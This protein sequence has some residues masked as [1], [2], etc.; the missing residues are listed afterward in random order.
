MDYIDIS[1]SIMQS[2]IFIF[3][4]NYCIDEIK[5][6]NKKFIRYII[7][8]SAIIIILPKISNSILV[9]SF[10]THICTLVLTAYSFY[11]QKYKNV[12]IIYSLIYSILIAWIF[13]FGNLSFGILGQILPSSYTALVTATLMYGSQILLFCLCY[14]FRTKIKQ[15]YKM[16]IYENISIQYIILFSFIP[17]FLN[18]FNF[19]TYEL[20]NSYFMYLVFVA[21][22][23]FLGVSIYSF[24]KIIKKANYISKLNRT[25][26]NKNDELKRIKNSYGLQMSCLYELCDVGKYDSVTSL[27]K[28]IINENGTNEVNSSTNSLSLLSLATRHAIGDEITILIEDKADLKLSAMDEIELYRIIVNIVNNAKRAMKNRGTLIARSFQDLKNILITIENDG[29]KIPEEVI[30]KIFE[31][32]FTTKEN[33]DKNHGYGLSIAKEL[34]EKYN[35]KIFVESNEVITKFTISLPIKNMHIC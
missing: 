26:T 7:F 23:I 19:I 31:L 6:N 25:L 20:D 16:I 4:I 9:S 22:F 18:S 3:L 2:I 30:G 27:L 14:I 17:D 28:S 33:S 32:G 10:L 13:L 11:K 24:A 15:I 29:E 8:F 35:G 1:I 5:I 34:I 21:L 12:V